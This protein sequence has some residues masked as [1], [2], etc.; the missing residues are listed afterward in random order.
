MSLIARRRQIQVGL[1]CRHHVPIRVA[2][3]PLRPRRRDHRGLGILHPPWSE[4]LPSTPLTSRAVT[5]KEVH[6]PGPSVF[7][8]YLAGAGE[9]T[10]VSSL[11]N[12]DRTSWRNWSFSLFYIADRASWRNH[13]FSILYIA[14]RPSWRNRSFRLY[15]LENTIIRRKIVHPLTCTGPPFGKLDI[16]VS[17]SLLH[18]I[19]WMAFVNFGGWITHLVVCFDTSSEPRTEDSATQTNLR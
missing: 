5:Q 14:N 15:I 12:V 9:R 3:P 11:Y 2:G 13:R 16:T 17:F 1:S 6:S 18:V 19:L 4:F 7:F 8:I 10:T